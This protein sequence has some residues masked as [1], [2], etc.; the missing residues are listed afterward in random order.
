MPVVAIV[1]KS[2]DVYEKMLNNMEE[3]RARHGRLI[4]VVEKGD[5]VAG[6]KA[7]SIIEIP[8][9]PEGLTPILSVLPLQLLAY[10]IAVYLKREIDQPR[11]LAKSVT[12]E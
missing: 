12:V 1:L 8:R 7:E 6:K 10:Y 5:K 3:V 4:A 9:A 2:T 11:N